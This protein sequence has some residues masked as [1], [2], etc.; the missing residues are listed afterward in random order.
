V[1]LH[2]GIEAVENVRRMS[3]GITVI[4]AF[5]D[6]EG[7][8]EALVALTLDVRRAAR[9]CE[10]CDGIGLDPVF[11]SVA[12]VRQS[13]GDDAAK[14]YSNRQCWRCQGRGIGE[15]WTA[16]QG[17][18]VHRVPLVGAEPN[19]SRLGKLVAQLVREAWKE[20]TQ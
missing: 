3:A 5:F 11:V 8:G 20:A 14:E 9:P 4:S 7:K 18:T 17:A 6:S 12:K 2:R 1:S 13:G 10:R 19:T 16:A 15:G